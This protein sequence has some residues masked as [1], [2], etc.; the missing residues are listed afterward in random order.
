MSGPKLIQS[1]ANGW[2]KEWKERRKKRIKKIWSNVFTLQN[3][4]TFLGGLMKIKDGSYRRSFWF[5][6]EWDSRIW[7][8]L[9]SVCGLVCRQRKEPVKNGIAS[10]ALCCEAIDPQCPLKSRPFNMWD[11]TVFFKRKL[12]LDIKCTPVPNPNNITQTA[13]KFE[14]Q[15]PT[16]IRGRKNKPEAETQIL[17]KYL[18]SLL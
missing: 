1:S 7:I 4:Q 6:V 18:P 15:E 3:T 2:A 11:K 5:G 10:S 14:T 9:S 17:N 13:F 16:A 8:P 12:I